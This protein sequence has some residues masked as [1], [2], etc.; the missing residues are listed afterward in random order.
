MFKNI[1]APTEFWIQ[2]VHLAT[3][4]SVDPE[5]L[6]LPVFILYIMSCKASTKS[7]PYIA[8]SLLKFSLVNVASMFSINSFKNS[9]LPTMFVATSKSDNIVCDTQSTSGFV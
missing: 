4:L 6:F 3:C 1:I 7:R 8:S 2:V 5:L 9:F